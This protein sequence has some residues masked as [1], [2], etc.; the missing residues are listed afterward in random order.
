MIVLLCILFYFGR[1]WN[2]VRYRQLLLSCAI[3]MGTLPSL[4]ATSAT[5]TSL[6][7]SWRMSVTTTA[8][9]WS[10]MW[11][12]RR[13]L[14]SMSMEKGWVPCIVWMSS[15][16]STQQRVCM[17]NLYTVHVHCMCM[18]QSTHHLQPGLISSL[19][20]Y[21]CIVLLYYKFCVEVYTGV[22]VHAIISTV[23]HVLTHIVQYSNTHNMYVW[24]SH[25]A[26]QP[27][28]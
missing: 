20:T 14:T 12:R 10:T 25:W 23:L 13:S 18:Y 27:R 3:V 24:Y 7:G 1:L 9:T 6:W 2:T 28:L 22:H 15:W 17:Y 21:T 4:P 26:Y 16:Y 11:Q 19:T 8:T 5:T